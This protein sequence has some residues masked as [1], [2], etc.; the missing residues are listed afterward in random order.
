MAGKY[1]VTRVLMNAES[2]EDGMGMVEVSKTIY[3][4]NLKDADD[5][6][7]FILE[8]NYGITGLSI[9][10]IITIPD[11]VPKVKKEDE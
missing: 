9:G 5:E 3:A 10:N 6:L 11:I 7:V 4:V 8:D 1:K 2:C